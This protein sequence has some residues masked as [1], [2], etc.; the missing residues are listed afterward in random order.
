MLGMITPIGSH[1]RTGDGGN[2]KFAQ[3]MANSPTGNGNH[4]RGL[5]G[6]QSNPDL[7]W[8]ALIP[9]DTFSLRPRDVVTRS[10]SR[11]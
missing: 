1:H 5:Y 4:S 7:L 8:F 10:F 11:E 2:A 6:R 3:V 9:A